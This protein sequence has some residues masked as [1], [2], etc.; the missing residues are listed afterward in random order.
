MW[1]PNSKTVA[2]LGIISVV[3][4]ILAAQLGSPRVYDLAMTMT[5]I[6]MLAVFVMWVVPIATGATQDRQSR[7]NLPPQ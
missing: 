6:C 2:H 1:M 3:I 4:A 5:R 7:S